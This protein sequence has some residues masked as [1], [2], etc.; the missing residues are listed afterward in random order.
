MA[1]ARRGA[2][3]AAPWHSTAGRGRGGPAG[4]RIEG[5]TS[6]GGGMSA[7]DARLGAGDSDKRTSGVQPPRLRLPPPARAAT[8]SGGCIGRRPPPRIHLYP[9]RRTVRQ[10]LG[11]VPTGDDAAGALAARP[12]RRRRRGL[13]LSSPRRVAPGG[14]RR[15]VTSGIGTGYGSTMSSSMRLAADGRR[16]PPCGRPLLFSSIAVPL[17]SPLPARSGSAANPSS[18]SSCSPL[19]WPARRR[20]RRRGA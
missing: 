14:G 13:H 11:G 8:A 16:A 7:A 3:A 19:P 18:S 6:N 17:S 10:E 12:K 4:R 9:C 1:S 20:D 2:A 15:G 5:S